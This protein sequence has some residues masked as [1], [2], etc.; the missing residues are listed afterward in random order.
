MSTST[1][2]WCTW[3]LHKSYLPKGYTATYSSDWDPKRT[4]TFCDKVR[5]HATS[6]R[7]MLELIALR[8]RDC[9]NTHIDDRE[10]TV[11]F[12]RRN[13]IEITKKDITTFEFDDGVR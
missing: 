6:K 1:N 10:K 11:T 9:F 5:I 12:T 8:Y 4:V 3:H 13:M 2:A 7:Q